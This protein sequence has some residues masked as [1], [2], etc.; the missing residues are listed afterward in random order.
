MKR[1]RQ[2]DHGMF[3]GSRWKWQ[4]EDQ[5]DLRVEEIGTNL[6]TEMFGEKEKIVESVRDQYLDHHQKV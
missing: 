1:H 6:L 4:T 2:A 5:S 3:T